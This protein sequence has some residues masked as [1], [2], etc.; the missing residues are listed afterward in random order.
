M[1]IIKHITRYNKNKYNLEII[2]KKFKRVYDSN[3]SFDIKNAYYK[4]G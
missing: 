1:D 3:I 2:T 4:F